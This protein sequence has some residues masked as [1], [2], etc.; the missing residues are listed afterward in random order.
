M[1]TKLV[2]SL[3]KK[4]KK[5]KKKEYL[6][7]RHYMFGFREKRGTRDA[8]FVF[9]SVLREKRRKG[10]YVAMAMFADDIVLML[11]TGKELQTALDECTLFGWKWGLEWNTNKGKSEVMIWRGK[12]RPVGEKRT[13]VEEKVDDREW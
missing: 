10:L 7:T 1:A 4:K 6:W 9:N 8:L 11:E 5:K 12:K 2:T 13:G 3:K